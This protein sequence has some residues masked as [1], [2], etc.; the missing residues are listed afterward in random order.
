MATAFLL[1]LSTQ[2]GCAKRK[3]KRNKDREIKVMLASP[4]KKHFVERI[5]IQ[6]TVLP[7]EFAKFVSKISEEVPAVKDIDLAVCVEDKNGMSAAAC[8]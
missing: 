1:A 6:G 2:T 3:V 7:D 8:V 5:P 4:E